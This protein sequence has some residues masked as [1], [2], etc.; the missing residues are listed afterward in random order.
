M[1][2]VAPAA[3][4]T[5]P[6]FDAFGWLRRNWWLPAGVV[7]LLAVVGYRQVTAAAP[8]LPAPDPV[9]VERTPT[10]LLATPKLDPLANFAKPLAPV[11]QALVGP[12]Y[13]DRAELARRMNELFGQGLNDC[14]VYIGSDGVSWSVSAV[15][16]AGHPSPIFA[17]CPWPPSAVAK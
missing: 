17:G 12:A 16:S 9:V 8:V 5:R 7:L 11:S 3:G 1:S 10:T 14:Q 6:A 15:W 13:E 2:A 4:P